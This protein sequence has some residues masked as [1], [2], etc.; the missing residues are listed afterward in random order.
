MTE[1]IYKFE[2]AANRTWRAEDRWRTLETTMESGNKQY[3]SK[4]RRGRLFILEFKKQ[5]LTTEEPQGIIDFF[6]A[7]EGRHEAFLWDYKKA[8]GT[9]EELTVRFAHDTLDRRVFADSIYTFQIELEEQLT[10][11]L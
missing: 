9:T 6:N 4:G 1:E 2:F 11:E 10:W 5:N 8:D 7:R 3:R